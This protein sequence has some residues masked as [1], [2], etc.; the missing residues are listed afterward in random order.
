FERARTLLVLGRIR[1][2]RG[3]RRAAR[4]SLALAIEIF[5]ELG[6]RPWAE[7]ARTELARIGVRHAPA[8]LT[9]NEELVARLAAEG[10]TNRDIAA[11]LFMSRRTVEAN[12]ARAYRKLGIRTRAQLGAKMAR[13]EDQTSA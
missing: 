5:D 10:L 13:F 1:R 6:T 12:L 7:R 2:R 4:E 8:E 9:V 11:Q 3:E